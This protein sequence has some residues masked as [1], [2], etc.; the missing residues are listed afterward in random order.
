MVNIGQVLHDEEFTSCAK[1]TTFMENDNESMI[2]VTG[3]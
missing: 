1:Y 2:R 3:I